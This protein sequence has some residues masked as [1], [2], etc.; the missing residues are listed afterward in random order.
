MKRAVNRARGA[1]LERRSMLR[2]YCAGRQTEIR[3][4]K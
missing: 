3:G 2:L 1:D 4:I